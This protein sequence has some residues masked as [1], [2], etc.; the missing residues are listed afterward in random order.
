MSP[1]R[2]RRIVEK[3]LCNFVNKILRDFFAMYLR[4]T[5]LGVATS[6]IICSCSFLIAAFP[7]KG[8]LLYTN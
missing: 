1:W 4:Q 2:F 7:Q 6:G 8:A 3:R 5:C